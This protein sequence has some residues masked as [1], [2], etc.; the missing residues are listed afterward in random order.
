MSFTFQWPRFSD[1]FHADAIQMLTAAL[2]KG[3]KPPVIAD[4]I[5]VVELEMGTQPPELEIRDIG[6]LTMDQFR[7][8]FR[9]TYSG[10]A[11]IVLRTKVQANPLNHKQPDIHLMGGSRGML[12]AKQPLV[13]PMLLRLSHFKLNSYVVL[14]VSRQK[15]I[16]LVFKT[17]PL[18]N[19]DINSTFDSIAVI[20]KFI[21]REI[22]GQLRQMFREDLPGIIHRLSQQWVKAKVEAPYSAKRPG[23]STRERRLDTMSAP[24]LNSYRSAR[25]PSVGLQ[26]HLTLRRPYGMPNFGRA[27]T[28]SVMSVSSIGR[29][30]S[31]STTSSPSTTTTPAPDASASF[32][33]LE[34]YDPTYGL[35][36][37]G[38]PAKSVFS[39]FRSLFAPSK[40]LVDLTEEA[41]EVDDSLD[42]TASYGTAN[43]DD[44]ISDYDPPPSATGPDGA[45]EYETVPAVGG[46][47]ITRPRIYHSQSQIQPSVDGPTEA[48]PSTSVRRPTSS[49]PSGAMR[50]AM[51]RHSLSQSSLLSPSGYGSPYTPYFTGT[52][53]LS[54]SGSVVESLWPDNAGDLSSPASAIP[55]VPPLYYSPVQRPKSS[56]SI[57]SQPSRSSD[58]THSVPTPPTLEEEAGIQMN[59]SR[60]SSF[61]SS[62]IDRFQPG[63]PSDQQ[64]FMP[65]H[66]PKIVLRPAVNSSISKLSTLSHS[67]HTLSPYTRT[68]EH[69]TVRSVPPRESSSGPSSSIEKQPVKA[70][71]RRTHHLGGKPAKPPEFLAHDPSSSSLP[72]S[73]FDAS[74]MDRYFRNNDDLMPHYPDRLA[75]PSPYARRPFP[76]QS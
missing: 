59:R 64:Y 1:Q 13:V 20:Q 3:N 32:P 18:Q 63:S 45:V 74:E 27:R 67:N 43:W 44:L 21:Q 5:E 56:S 50:A 60:R 7:G 40:G 71:R 12:A 2:N 22:E 52:S 8:I 68:L 33:D 42:E 47:T 53:P 24:D 29:R 72:M 75:S 31:P 35:R 15:G 70:K 66:D 41:S 46:G 30:P 37:E 61:A 57:H 48:G 55:P 36:P 6:E 19:V 9:L 4:K 17:D 76:Y 28:A 25:L 39:G 38:L 69:Y 26:P 73:D 62:N 34:N 10:D 11:H 23:P 16:T 54:T 65:D 51:Y 14:V 49:T 58:R